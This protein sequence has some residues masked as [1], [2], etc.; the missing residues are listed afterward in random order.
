MS[1]IRFDMLGRV[2]CNRRS[3]RTVSWTIEPEGTQRNEKQSCDQPWHVCLY[4]WVHL[5]HLFSSPSPWH[6]ATPWATSPHHSLGLADVTVREIG[7]RGTHA[8]WWRLQNGVGKRSQHM[9]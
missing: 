7:Y 9:S 5:L 6:T 1:G 4:T 3:K 8:K 2:V